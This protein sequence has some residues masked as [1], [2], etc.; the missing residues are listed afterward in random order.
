MNI[1]PANTAPLKNV[2][3]SGVSATVTSGL[4]GDVAAADGDGEGVV[5]GADS[6]KA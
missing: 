5:D 2:I 6:A 3:T 4:V 1:P